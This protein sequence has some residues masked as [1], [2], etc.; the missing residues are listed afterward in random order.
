MATLDDRKKIV[1][2]Y[3][4]SELEFYTYCKAGVKVH[5]VT[6]ITNSILLS[7]FMS[8]PLLRSVTICVCLE[9]CFTG[10]THH[11]GDAWQQ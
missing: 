7:F 4:D 11:Y 2:R 6:L 9:G 8:F 10:N 5:V 3:G 1:A